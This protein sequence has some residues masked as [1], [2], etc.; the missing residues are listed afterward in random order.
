MK[1]AIGQRFSHPVSLFSFFFFNLQQHVQ[2]V[3][4]PVINTLSSADVA[5]CE[6][7]RL[8]RPASASYLALR[9]NQ[10]ESVTMITWPNTVT[11][12]NRKKEPKKNQ[13]RANVY[14]SVCLSVKLSCYHANTFDSIYF[15]FKQIYRSMLWLDFL[16]LGLIEIVLLCSGAPISQLSQLYGFNAVLQHQFFF[17]FF[18]FFLE[19]EQRMWPECRAWLNEMRRQKQNKKKNSFNNS[20]LKNPETLSQP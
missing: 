13:K 6:H 14:F 4:E 12:D 2:H 8:Q 1:R 18:S 10:S 15:L 7:C 17:F 9:R 5:L 19:A 20:L 3:S 16:L 11:G